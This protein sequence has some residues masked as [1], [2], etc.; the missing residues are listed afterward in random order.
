M[1]QQVR[2]EIDE[3]NDR[4]D[5]ISPY[6]IGVREPQN[7]EPAEKN[8]R[9]MTKNTYDQLVENIKQDGGLSSL[10]F[11]WHDEEDNAHIISGHHRISAAQDAGIE[12]VLY[13]YTD[14][15]MTEDERTAA[16]LS[17]N[18]I[19]GQDD[20]EVLKEQW[21]SIKNIEAKQYSGLDEEFFDNYDTVSIATFNEA[22]LTAQTIE[23][24]FVP[25]ELD[26]FAEQLERIGSSKKAKFIADERDY[27]AFADILMQFKQ[28]AEVYNTS[29]A[30]A[31]MVE[32]V[33]R[34]CHFVHHHERDPETGEWGKIHKATFDE[35]NE[36]EQA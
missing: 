6:R 35:H 21:A 33:D 5:G 14:E 30:V 29:A 28:E 17:H 9:F 11:C 8:A 34:F 31:L 26:Q 27:Q 12:H 3:L 20:L 19:V 10:P 7:F 2:G 32:V 4:L 36:S 22:G 23:I 25:H 16:Q 1:A 15:P 13:L 24:K 18:A